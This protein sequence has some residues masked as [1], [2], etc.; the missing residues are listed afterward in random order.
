MKT[1]SLVTQATTALPPASEQG[2]GLFSGARKGDVKRVHRLPQL[3]SSV[4]CS[5]AT[6]GLPLPSGS[7]LG[8]LAPSCSFHRS[9]PT[10]AA[11]QH[12]QASDSQGPS[13]TRKAP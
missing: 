7:I 11:K 5:D 10:R 3:C 13:E 12:D 9:R 4:R 1:L 8:V 2:N 6:L